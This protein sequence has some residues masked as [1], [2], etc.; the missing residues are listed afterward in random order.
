MKNFEKTRNSLTR[1]LDRWVIWLLGHKCEQCGSRNTEYSGHRW[2]RG[3][4][5]ACEQAYGDAGCY[6]NKCHHI[7]WDDSLAE[8]KAKLPAWCKPYNK[9]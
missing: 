3:W 4:N 8:H 1:L 2:A 5:N 9:D 7:T 6:C